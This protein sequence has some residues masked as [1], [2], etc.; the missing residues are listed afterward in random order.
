M[1]PGPITLR[2]FLA[3]MVTFAASAAVAQTPQPRVNH[4]GLVK[5]KWQLA[6]QSSTFANMDFASMVEMLHHMTIHHIELAPGQAVSAGHLA[7]IG[8]DMSKDDLAAFFTVLKSSHLDVV[9]VGPVTLSDNEAADRKVFEWARALKAKNIVAPYESQNENRPTPAAD[10][11]GMAMIDKLANEFK[12]KVAF[13]PG[14]A[15]LAQLGSAQIWQPGINLDGTSKQLGICLDTSALVGLNAASV[16][17]SLIAINGRLIELHLTDVDSKGNAEPFGAGTVDGKAILQELS[18]ENF[19][20]ILAVQ[21]T[22]GNEKDRPA[23]FIDAV[24]AFS[25]I[26]GTVSGVR[27]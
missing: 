25:D 9:S 10:K 16:T 6:C 27:E 13:E 4:K 2:R 12:V 14:L 22:S 18:D 26:V 15:D 21:V 11:Q 5:L 8:P 7:T 1:M 20:G 3:A 24:N 19:K 23:N 17:Q